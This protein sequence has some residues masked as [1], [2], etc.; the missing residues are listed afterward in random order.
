MQ[1]TKNQTRAI[2]EKGTD[3]LVAAAAGSGKTAV[4]VERIR[5]L[6][7]VDK[8]SIDRM[9]VLTFTKAAAS[10]M[11]E[12][13]F[14]S[15]LEEGL[16]DQIELLSRAHIGTFDSFALEIIKKYYHLIDLDPGVNIGDETRIEILK[17]EALDDLFE[18]HFKENDPAFLDFLDRYGETTESRAVREM[19]LDMH[20][21]LMPMPDPFAYVPLKD[22]PDQVDKLMSL[23][24][25]RALEALYPARDRFKQVY[26]MMLDIKAEKLA[27]KAAMDLSI[28]ESLIAAIEVDPETGFRALSDGFKFQTFTATKEEKP[29]YEPI[30]EEIKELRDAAK[31]A[32]AKAKDSFAGLSKLTIA[33]ETELMRPFVDML[34]A[35]TKEFDDIFTEKKLAEKLIDY[36]DCEHLALKIL[37]FPE[38]SDE[39]KEQ[40]DCIFIDEFQDSNSVQFEL[41]K[42]VSRGSNFFM[43]G[44]VKQSIY[45]F[46]KAEPDLFMTLYEKYKYDHDGGEV[47]DLNTNFR[48]KESVID[49]INL[50]FGKL[51]NKKT[52]GITYDSDAALV[53]GSPYDGPISYASKLYCISKDDA[54][55]IDDDIAELKDAELEAIK[56]VEL[57]KKHH[58]QPIFDDKK[59]I[60]RPLQYKDMVI[61]MGSVRTDGEIFYKKLLDA[62]I[63]VYL[64]RSEGYFDTLEIQVF[65]NLL[66]L[67]DNKKQDLPLLSV[68]SCP[69][70]GFTVNELAEI[71]LLD[72]EHTFADAFEKA[73]DEAEP[74]L[75][76]KCLKFRT[77]LDHYRH[78]KGIVPLDELLFDILRSSGYSD[79]TA[80]QNGG[81]QKTANLRALID[82]AESY[83]KD[84]LSGLSGFISFIEMLMDKK[85]SID[86]GQA[87]ILSEDSDCVRIMTI[88]KSKGLEF[89]F[90]L[91][92]RL[93][94]DFTRQDRN[95]IKPR[96]FH[97]EL[98]TALKLVDPAI[99]SSYSPAA[100][101]LIR[102]KNRQE[103]YAERIR[104]LYVAM[105]RAKDILLFTS[106][107]KNLKPVYN[108]RQ[109]SSFCDMLRFALP[110]EMT[111]IRDR[112]DISDIS[113]GIKQSRAAF[114]KE[115]KEGYGTEGTVEYEEVKK[116][117]EYPYFPE[118]SKAKRKYSVSE[119]A[120]L[121]REGDVEKRL[122]VEGE[123]EIPLFIQGS[124]HKLTAAER[125][126][127]YHAVMEHLDFKKAS[128]S[129]DVIKETIRSLADKK[130]ITEQM[131]DAVDPAK[132]AAFFKTEIGRRAAEAAELSKESPF[133]MKYDYKGAEVMVQGTIDCWFEEAGDLILLD[134]KSNYIDPNDKEGSY[135]HM[136]E[137]YMPQLALYKAA[138]E[139]MSGRKVKEA[140]LYLFSS[141]DSL[142]L[143]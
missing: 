124:F 17:Q 70:F 76:E 62:D 18:K 121:I 74:E 40:F 89:P 131:A 60:E 56:A 22:G 112:S 25:D 77:K 72:R 53:K 82:K 94:K 135:E 66:R 14:K 45:R 99:S 9:L 101:K 108:E 29:A 42:R 67:I 68:L 58:G 7:I 87:G 79:F 90:V 98:G 33:K 11:R 24:Q 61:L 55:D 83:E 10:E 54:D 27:A 46:R 32:V 141:D 31:K 88:H 69:V 118:Q 38:A 28:A 64:D 91:V 130:I 34:F 39:Y 119:L 127:A 8:I 71:R 73:C 35:L 133:V 4:L 109:A 142:R 52:C 26:D 140:D 20:A 1:W 63:P 97:K 85:M 36:S 81:E 107:V 123:E 75:K 44:D 65:L 16:D 93:G 15:L 143:V 57:I 138:L 126:T 116:L 92:S 111:E 3:L 106:C 103:D 41:L 19:I 49:V 122:V 78:E 96:A 5:K 12:K 110:P 6:V 134:Y 43:V 2:D 136:K 23:A 100:L 132:I 30:K 128:A 80:A 104:V 105:T 120:T 51:M 102:E 47:V 59:G 117:I 113:T 21:F 84:N 115:I 37:E 129:I 86:M 13:I 125:G 137:L 139:K 95:V 50:V 114:E 48:S